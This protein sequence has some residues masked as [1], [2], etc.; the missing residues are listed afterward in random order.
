M[1]YLGNDADA[2]ANCGRFR[3]GSTHSAKTRSQEN[4]ARQIV[5]AEIFPTGVQH[6]QL[7]FENRKRILS[8]S[9]RDPIKK[10]NVFDQSLQ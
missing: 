10:K 8:P 5:E 9:F 7:Q 3:L 4:F 6:S 2:A 1:S